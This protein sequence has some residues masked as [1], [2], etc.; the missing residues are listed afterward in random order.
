M[1]TGG[2]EMRLPALMHTPGSALRRTEH[3]GHQPRPPPTLDDLG[4][5]TSSLA[6]DSS[7]FGRDDYPYPDQLSYRQVFASPRQ[8]PPL[9]SA[10]AASAASRASVSSAFEATRMPATAAAAMAA[11]AVITG[12]GGSGSSGG[13]RGSYNRVGG[14][15]GSANGSRVGYSMGGSAPGSAAT[16][17]PYADNSGGVEPSDGGDEASLLVEMESE[18]A[19]LKRWLSTAR[20]SH[21]VGGSYCSP[22]A[23]ASW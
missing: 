7:P 3:E 6:G 13:Y 21:G 20:A 11:V 23:V 5:G 17:P 22:T 10:T 16:S 18:A 19:E 14:S 15:G 2:E 8:P 12:G 1:S 9:P 4:G